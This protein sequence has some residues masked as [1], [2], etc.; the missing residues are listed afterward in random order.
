MN[1]FYDR[2]NLFSVKHN[3]EFSKVV[4]PLLCLF[5]V[6]KFFYQS[7]N[8]E[9][10]FCF[11][12]S[13]I[14]LMQ[15]YFEYQMQDNNPFITQFKATKSGIYLMDTVRHRKYQQDLKRL[16]DTFGM[17]HSF[18]ISKIEGAYC[19]QYGFFLPTMRNDLECVLLNQLPLLWRFI[20]Y[21]E[22]EMGH[23]LHQM[24]EYPI[25]LHAELQTGFETKEPMLP[26]IELQEGVFVQFLS[27]I[28][29]SCDLL[30]QYGITEREKE[31]IKF[32]LL[33]KTA[34]EIAKMLYLSKRTIEHRIE[35]IKAK[36]Q[37]KTKSELISRLQNM[38]DIIH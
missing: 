14:D 21:F 30:M 33:G 36:L 16:E 31:C 9:G 11:I 22:A 29:A 17:R 20:G 18:T 27:Q 26:Q 25:D 32:I 13:H 34:P 28:K 1:N 38:V 10:R 24:R 8:K 2:L 7:V 4:E 23:V 6:K 12:G 3:K 19:H 35:S 5:N 15:Y 37:C